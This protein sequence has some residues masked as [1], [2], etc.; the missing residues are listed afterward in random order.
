RIISPPLAAGHLPH[1]WGRNDSKHS[2]LLLP[3]SHH[4]ERCPSGGK[5]RDNTKYTVYSLPHLTMGKG[6]HRAERGIKE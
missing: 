4:G 5:G 2:V 1:L 3:P 6:A